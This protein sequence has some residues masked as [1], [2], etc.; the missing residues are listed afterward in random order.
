MSDQ[1]KL[2]SEIAVGVN[3]E[4]SFL[5]DVH[6]WGGI[7]I[8]KGEVLGGTVRHW[9]LDRNFLKVGTI[10]LAIP[11]DKVEIKR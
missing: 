11:I 9:Q 8:K 1:E 5:E 10:P 3:V 2:I 7:V 4:C 6:F